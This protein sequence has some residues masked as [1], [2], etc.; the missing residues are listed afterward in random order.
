MLTFRWGYLVAMV[1]FRCGY[2]VAM[3]TFRCGYLVATVTFRCGYLVGMVT[4]RCGYLVPMVKLIS[5]GFT[6]MRADEQVHIVFL[7]DFLCYI[8]TKVTPS[9]TE[10]I[11]GTPQLGTGITPQDVQNLCS[12]NIR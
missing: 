3:V 4:F 10:G 6:L 2:L 12:T 9:T 7:Q 5:F 1:T 11:W 8:W